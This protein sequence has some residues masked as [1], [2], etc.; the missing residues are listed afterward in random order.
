MLAK[1]LHWF[2]TLLVMVI[3]SSC[4]RPRFKTKS[5]TPKGGLEWCR[6]RDCSQVG[7]TKTVLTYLLTNVTLAKA[8]NKDIGLFSRQFYVW[9][10]QY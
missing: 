4:Y 8:Y 5:K 9:F 1:Q 6:D 2:F 7:K 10:L 3:Y